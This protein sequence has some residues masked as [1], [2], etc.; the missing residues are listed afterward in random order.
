MS[1]AYDLAHLRD[2]SET[3]TRNGLRVVIYRT[4]RGWAGFVEET[5]RGGELLK[6]L[7][8]PD[9]MTCALAA[10]RVVAGHVKREPGKRGSTLRGR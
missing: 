9:P 3:F 4:R 5:R 1:A 7:S 10:A 6:Y 8:A 2:G